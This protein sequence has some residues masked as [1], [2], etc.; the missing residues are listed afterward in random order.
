MFPLGYVTYRFQ[1]PV[2]RDQNSRDGVTRIHRSRFV[3]V[4]R[5]FVQQAAAQISDGM[6]DF[7]LVPHRPARWPPGVMFCP[8]FARKYRPL[9]RFCRLC[10]LV[11]TVPSII[12]VRTASMAWKRSSV[13]SRSG[14]SNYF[15]NLAV[16]VQRPD[17]S[18]E[19]PV[20]A[21]RPSWS[22]GCKSEGS[23]SSI[24]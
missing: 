12:W 23:G 22:A 21:N 1:A 17:Q 15:N 11:S 18:F 9:G 24:A 3:N 6:K 4:P 13:R 8:H 10:R 14:P 2:L 5:A 20:F 19:Q 7:G 16:A